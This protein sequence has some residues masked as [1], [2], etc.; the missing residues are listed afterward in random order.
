MRAWTLGLLGAAILATACSSDTTTP[1]EQ[2]EQRASIPSDAVALTIETVINTQFSGITEPGRSV[3]RDGEEWAAFWDEVMSTVL[4]KPPVPEV[5]FGTS[6]VVV[7]AMGMRSSAGHSI[8]IED[9]YEAESGYY[10]AVL[11]MSP[12]EGCLAATVITAPI[13]AAVVPRTD[14][15]VIFDELVETLDCS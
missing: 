8:V 1:T 7:A 14:A 15:N 6:M 13:S 3:I 12:E 9:V 2:P 10:V 5:D 4:P 11:E